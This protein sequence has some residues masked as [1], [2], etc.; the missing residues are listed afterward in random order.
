MGSRANGMHEG[1]VT[2]RNIHCRV[3]ADFGRAKPGPLCQV[4]DKLAWYAAVLLIDVWGQTR[5][6]TENEMA[7]TDHDELV[8][9]PFGY[10]RFV[11]S[12]FAASRRS[13]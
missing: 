10:F 11:T 1:L 13:S 7:L 4:D 2:D 6:A 8:S 9:A 12:A 3:C 5:A